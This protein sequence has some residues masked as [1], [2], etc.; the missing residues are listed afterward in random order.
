MS[1]PDR[2]AAAVADYIA[3]IA[4]RTEHTVAVAESLTSGRIACH[5]GAAPSSSS[6]FRGGV[7]AYGDEVKHQV[8]GV[9]SGPVISEA[10]AR[11]MARGV[12]KL[13]GADAAVAVTGVGGPAEQEGQPVGTVWFG[14]VN[15]DG[16][17]V[18]QQRFDGEP[19]DILKATTL[20]ALELLRD[21]LR[22]RVT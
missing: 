21:A 19:D 10:S 13:L 7:T 9:P 8:L 6:W 18:E 5:L 2:L 11:A 16:D 22:A 3:D 1:V 15:G 20:R 4:R 14:V 17:H 12:A